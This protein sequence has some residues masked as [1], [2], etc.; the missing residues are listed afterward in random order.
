MRTATALFALLALGCAGSPKSAVAAPSS[1]AVASDVSR[2]ETL[3]AKDVVSLV[4]VSDA[5]IS[6][7]GKTIAFV[8]R[9]PRSDMDPRGGSRSIIWIVAAKG[10]EPVRFTAPDRSSF[11]PKWSPDGRWLTFRSSRSGD[12]GAQIYR[13]SPRGGEPERLTDVE[14]GVAHFDWSPDGKHIGFLAAKAKSKAERKAEEAGRDVRLTDVK[15]TSRRL[16]VFDPGGSDAPKAVGSKDHHVAGFAWAPDS[17]RLVVQASTRADVDGVMMYSGLFV[18]DVSGGW[19]SLTKTAGKLGALAWSPDGTRIAFLGASDISD[20]TAGVLH[21]VAASGGTAR[22]LTADYEG[23]GASVVWPQD[24]QIVMLANEGTRTVLNGVDPSS[25]KRKPL[26]RSGPVCRRVRL[27]GKSAVCVGSTGTHPG[28]VF[29]GTLGKSLRRVTHSNPWLATKTLGT[30]EVVRWKAADGLEIEGVLIHPVGAAKGKPA[31]LAV[32]PHGGPEGITLDGWGTYA[33]YPA[34]L[35]A[36]RGFAVLMPN[37]RGSQGRGVAFGKADHND[38]G[39]KEFEDV[40]AGIQHLASEGIVDADRVGM[41]G[42][43]YGGYFSGL[44]A[45]MHSKH[46]KAA[47]VGAAIT[48]WVSF[49]GTTEIEH[50]NSLVHWNLWPWENIE[51][52][53]LRSPMAHLERAKTATLVVHGEADTRVPPGQAMEL[54]RGLRHFGVTTEIALYPREGHGLSERAHQ[55]DFAERFVSFFEKHVAGAK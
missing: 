53:W 54:Y 23:T 27:A 33:G 41:G 31:P 48:N 1:S 40:L 46:F 39:G 2:S 13:I 4:S 38:L 42:W 8:R 9:T 24:G 21:V 20:P 14:G 25:G 44:A 34:Q 30:Q 6:P 55:L 43:S 16:Y 12:V 5:A 18:T 17:K 35:F 28:E 37:Y 45:T 19:S 7:D 50:E 49:S 36:N 11:E 26:L 3:T 10:G 15:G 52:A 22:P 32:L 29:T 47:M 51:L